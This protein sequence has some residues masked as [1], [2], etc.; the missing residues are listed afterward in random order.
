MT[1]VISR[2]YAD[3]KT[4]KGVA[5]QLSEAGFPADIIDMFGAGASVDDIAAARVTEGDAEAYANAMKKGNSLLI[6]R[7]PVTPFGA[8][9]AAMQTVDSVESI[10]AGVMHPNRYIEETP[11]LESFA[12][13]L[14]DHPRFLTQ[15]MGPGHPRERGLIS[16]GMGWRLLSPHRTKR[17]AS[18]D[19]GHNSKFIPFPLLKEK[20]YKRTA[21]EGGK[22]F[23]YN[24]ARLNNA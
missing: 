7:A 13:I 22:R 6:V 4:A 24:P 11:N 1:T 17:S 16:K 15:D 18:S 5:A 21:I 9:R 8:A 14:T 19:G 12:S 3:E 23:L 10:D 2:L 20:K